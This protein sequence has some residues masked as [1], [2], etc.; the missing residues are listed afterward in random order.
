MVSE[1]LKISPRI[2]ALPVVHGSG[3]FAIEVR[4]VMLS[5]KFDC[6]AVP[7]P[8]SFHEPVETAI[9]DL[10]NV[11]VVIQ[12]EGKQYSTEWLPESGYGDEESEEP[13][14]ECSYVPIDPCQPV[15]AALRI[16][17]QERI[18]RAFVDL[19]TE[20]FRSIPASLPD[21]YAVKKVAADKFAA[22]VL[23]A[24]PRPQEGQP[25]HR[26]AFM[27]QRLREL[28]EQYESI[29]FVCSLADWPWIREAYQEKT[30]CPVE[31]EHVEDAIVVQPESE[32]LVF[33]LG[34]L[35]Y[36]TGLYERAR[37]ELDDDE[38]LSF[39]GVKQLLLDTRV[40]YEAE[41]GQQ[42][43]RITPQLLSC[44]FRYV[45]NLSLIQRRMAP[46]LFTLITAAQQIAGDQF[47]IQL[48]ETA[49]DYPY[50][51]RLPQYPTINCG[52]GKGRLDDDD[53]M[54]MVSRLPGHAMEWR[55]IALNPMP[56]KWQAEQWGRGWNP[57]GQ[58]SWPPEDIAI[59]RF[60]T[61][62]KDAALD[63][64][65]NDL[66]RSE[67]FTA[68]MKDGLD[69]RETLRNWHTGDLYV[70]VVPPAKGKL[71]CVIMLFDSPADPR[72]YPWRITWHAE[73]HDESTLSLFAT[74]FLEQPVG[75]GI[76]MASYGGC[77]F[78]FPPLPIPDLWTDPRFNFT[79]TLEERLIAGACHHSDESHVALLSWGPPGPAWRRL[80]KKYKKKL[81]HVPMGRFSQETIQQLRM[82]HVLNGHEVRSFAADFIRR[83]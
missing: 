83:A 45:R 47:A 22:A 33:V 42:A 56:Q 62:I 53:P 60:R 52:N 6:L 76:C 58:C 50:I 5:Q 74:N 31:D 2:T 18:P 63:I 40:E 15:I 73:K 41:F 28:E 12:P 68:S 19:E 4:R 34:E 14:R 59:E 7:L 32:G 17:M 11:T 51:D 44:Y 67:K 10:P 29:L 3:D 75:P 38:N 48:I 24:I 71:D 80:A 46:D 55:T 64:M 82:F 70:K 69:I 36:I 20:N 26:V 1:F 9:H 30:E 39:D 79:D 23:P 16:A 61:S 54:H 77:M 72:D 21:P 35:P 81:V 37:A 25:E 57:N 65:G 27:A 43:R 66:A 8:G 13:T 78:R 49:R